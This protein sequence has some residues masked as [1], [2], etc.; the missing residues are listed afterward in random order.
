MASGPPQAPADVPVCSRWYPVLMCP[1]TGHRVPNCTAHL[2]E[3]QP[4]FPPG[5]PALPRS[6]QHRGNHILSNRKTIRAGRPPENQGPGEGSRSSTCSNSAVAQPGACRVEPR[7]CLCSGHLRRQRA[8]GLMAGRCPEGAEPQ[9]C[10]GTCP[11][12]PGVGW[13]PLG[14]VPESHPRKLRSQNT[15]IAWCRRCSPC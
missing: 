4:P 15:W 6:T 2:T 14:G 13:H 10:A 12:P 9:R 5:A 11:I 7:H 8:A 3:T 1:H